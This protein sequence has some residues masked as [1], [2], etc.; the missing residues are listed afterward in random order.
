MVHVSWGIVVAVGK[1]QQLTSQAETAF[2]GVGSRPVLGHVLLA[3]ESCPDISGVVVVVS[4]DRM[5]V[6]RA[7]GQRFGCAK[8][9]AVVPGFLQRRPSLG[10]GMKALDDDVS[11]VTVHDVSRPCVTPE[12]ISQAVAAAKRYGS[13][14]TASLITDPVQRAGKGH[15]G[16]ELLA[17]GTLWNVQSPQSFRRELLERAL[18]AADRKKRSLEDESSA[19]T[20]LREEVR[21]VPCDRANLRIRTA[22][23]LALAAQLLP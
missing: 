20:L 14:V 18:A 19:L 13:G 8:L 16:V 2:L 6:V 3:F 23:D 17:P 5:D 1:G 11:L 10:A 15:A 7:M 4:R 12:M 21:L 22:D 9:K